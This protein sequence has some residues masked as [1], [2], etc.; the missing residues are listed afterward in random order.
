VDGGPTRR[1][2]PAAKEFLVDAFMAGTAVS[3]REMRADYKAVVIRLL[4]IRGRRVAVQAVHALLCVSG[5]LV[6]MHHRVLKT[7]MALR[8][9]ARS[10]HKVRSGLVG[11]NP[12]AGPIDEEGRENQRKRNNNSDKNRSEGHGVHPLRKLF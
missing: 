11:F 10:P 12:G 6:L 9:F 3:R 1:G 8:T 4:L 2:V 5:H 7:R